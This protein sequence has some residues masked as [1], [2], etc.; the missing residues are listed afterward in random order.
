ME[1]RGCE[2]FGTTWSSSVFG[3]SLGTAK[4]GKMCTLSGIVLAGC[5]K[6]GLLWKDP[7]DLSLGGG[8]SFAQHNLLRKI[9]R[10]RHAVHFGALNEN[11]RKT[12]V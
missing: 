12:I 6:V 3:T 8:A 5:N 1:Q 11:G 10:L 7:I 9:V 2:Y 4:N